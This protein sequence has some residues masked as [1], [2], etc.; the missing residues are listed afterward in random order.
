MPRQDIV[1]EVSAENV[2]R[3]VE[4]ITTAI[5]SRLAG[6]PSARRIAE[7]SLQALR[8]PGAVARTA[9]L[10]ELPEEGGIADRRATGDLD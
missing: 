6:S 1:R 7:Y 4:H 10:G 5:P 3:H 2:R 8:E 9:G